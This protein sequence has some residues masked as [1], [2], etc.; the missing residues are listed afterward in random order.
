MMV[1][2]TMLMVVVDIENVGMCAVNDDAGGW[3]SGVG[4]GLGEGIEEI[5]NLFIAFDVQSSDVANIC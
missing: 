4:G 5:P 3:G 1:Q 2:T